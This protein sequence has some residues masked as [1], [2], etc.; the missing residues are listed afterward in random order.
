MRDGTSKGNESD[1]QECPS[2]ERG[3]PKSDAM[4]M[5]LCLPH[6]ESRLVLPDEGF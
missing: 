6:L 4:T 5:P 2:Y 3:Q 1:G